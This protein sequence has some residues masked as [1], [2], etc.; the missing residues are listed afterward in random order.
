[1]INNTTTFLRLVRFG[2][3]ARL[4]IAAG[5]V[6]LVNTAQAQQMYGVMYRTGSQ[7][8]GFGP[9]LYD[10]DPA[11]GNCTNP[12][13]INVNFCVG[14]AIDPAPPHTMY[15]LTDQLGRIN[16]ASGVTGKN[17]LF[18]VNPADG[19]AT[20]VGQLDPTRTSS[21]DPLAVNEGDIAFHPITGQLWGVSTRV[22]AA[23]LFT[24]DTTTGLGTLA[25]DVAVPPGVPPLPG[26][27]PAFDISAMAFNAAGELFLL[28]T[29]YPGVTGPARLY[30]V[31]PSTAIATQ[32][33]QWNTTVTM[34]TCAGMAFAPD[35]TLLIADGDFGSSNRLYRFDFNIGDLV[36]IGPTNASGNAGGTTTT[37]TG[38][39]GLTFLPAEPGPAC[40]ADVVR[41]GVVDGT[42]FVAFVNSFGVGDVGID[43]AAD[44]NLDGTIDG[45]DFIAFINAFAAGC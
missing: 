41:D 35:G 21:T 36:L 19:R 44:V 38:L 14:I 25:S 34:G 33:Q 4:L 24:I 43:A 13:V 8:N 15:G 39:A 30:K 12:R 17:L 11:T 32:V 20:R 40:L 45:N 23:R 18:T 9:K 27:G 3:A 42:D 26:T 5:G 22:T 7:T 16:N 6:A 2:A 37:W 29:T 1:M 31:D 10:V 28:D